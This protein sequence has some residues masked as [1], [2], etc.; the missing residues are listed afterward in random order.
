MA[1]QLL[2]Q[3]LIFNTM[4]TATCLLLLYSLVEMGLAWEKFSDIR[5]GT[6]SLIEAQSNCGIMLQAVVRR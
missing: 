4:R 1:G 5:T 2:M 6:P 3:W